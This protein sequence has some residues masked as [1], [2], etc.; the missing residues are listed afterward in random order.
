MGGQPVTPGERDRSMTKMQ[1][2]R[3]SELQVSG[4]IN[5]HIKC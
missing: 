5:D 2:F 3:V 4:I 1:N